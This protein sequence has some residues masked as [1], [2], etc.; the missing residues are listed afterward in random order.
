MQIETTC[1]RWAVYTRTSRRWW[2]CDWTISGTRSEAIRKVRD[3]LGPSYEAW[4]R[5]GD[6][7]C[8]R[9]MIKTWA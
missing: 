1:W 5:R 9:V 6:A 3:N 7:K 4:R 8:I 2:L